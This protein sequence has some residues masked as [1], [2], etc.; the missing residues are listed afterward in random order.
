MRDS[1]SRFNKQKKKQVKS[2]H[3]KFVIY[4]RFKTRALCA[5][6]KIAGNL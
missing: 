6:I 2:N 5:K 1:S 3:C 4:V